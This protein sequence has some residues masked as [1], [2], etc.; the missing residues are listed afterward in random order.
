MKI[1]ILTCARLPELLE[2]DQKLI[3]L[4]AKKNIAAKAVIWDDESVDWTEFDYLIF[5]NTWD[6]YQKEITFNLWLDKIESLGIKTLNP[7]SIIKKN[8]HKFYLKELEKEGISILPTIFLEKNSTSNLKELIPESWEKIVIKPAFSAGSYLTKLIDRSE[9]ESIQT[10]FKKHF[11]T[12][13]FLLQEFR[14]EIKELGETS[15]IFFDGKF[16]HAVNK[17][18]VENDFRVQI[19]YGGKYTLIQPNADL[20]LQAELVLSKIPEKLLYARVDGIVIENKL[21]LMEIELI[22]PD[23]YFD[24]ADGARERF[25]EA[26][27]RVTESL[28]F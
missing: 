11:E 18:P 5:R 24:L 10:E 23:L 8:K 22:E 21:H 28:S 7:I 27:L 4:F 6:Y 15:F 26:F 13:D 20:L 14:P 17:K 19:Q 1:G 16:S 9:L 25:V 12:K 2:S 3:P